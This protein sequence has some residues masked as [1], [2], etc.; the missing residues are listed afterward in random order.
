MIYKPKLNSYENQLRCNLNSY[1]PS[2]QLNKYLN[3][4]KYLDDI[5]FRVGRNFANLSENI[6]SMGYEL[7]VESIPIG[8]IPQAIVIIDNEGGLKNFLRANGVG[9]WSWPDSDIPAEVSGN[10]NMYPISN[11]MNS[12]LVLLPTH[13]N[14]KE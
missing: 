9:A 7:L 14:I 8:I 1:K 13:Q 5:K 4:D 6:E 10:V 11:F 12:K 3:N 2:W